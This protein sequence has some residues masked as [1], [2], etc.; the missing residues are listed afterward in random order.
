[1]MPPKSPATTTLR[2]ASRNAERDGQRRRE[3]IGAVVVRRGVG[4]RVV[5]RLRCYGGRPPFDHAAGRLARDARSLVV[6]PTYNEIENIETVLRQSRAALPDGARARRR[7]R[8]PRRHRRPGRGA[9]RRARLHRRAAPSGQ[10]RARHR[11][12]APASAAA[13]T[14]ATTSLIEMDADLSH[15]PAVLPAAR[16]ARSRTAPTSRSGRA[17]YPAARFPTGRSSGARSRASAAGTRGDAGSVG[18]RCHRGLPGLSRRGAAR[19]RPRRGPRR[20]LRLP[21]RDGVPGRT[22]T[23]AASSRCR[24]S[25]ATGRSGTR[26][27]RAGSSSRRSCS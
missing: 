26:R 23:A 21:D 6:L 15:D 24:S 20:R 22:A 19:H 5:H 4:S 1:M 18:A 11:R 2:K 14:R 10:G 8:Q 13:S 9:R 17:T 25:S 12:T 27:C 3:Q 7:R 16:A